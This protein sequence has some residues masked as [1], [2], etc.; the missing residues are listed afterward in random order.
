MVWVATLERR[1]E[2]G[3]LEGVRNGFADFL[4]HGGLVMEVG[5]QRV[6]SLIHWK[7]LYFV[8]LGYRL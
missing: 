5:D 8:S 3:V 2:I 7:D 1:K 4:A 6:V